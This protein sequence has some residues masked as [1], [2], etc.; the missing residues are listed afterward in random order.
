[1][2]KTLLTLCLAVITVTASAQKM[3]LGDFTKVDINGPYEVKIS[4]ANTC[5]V[6]IEASPDMAKLVEI[7]VEENELNLNCK[8]KIYEMK[9]RSYL[10]VWVDLPVL[11]RIEALG[12]SSIELQGRFNTKGKEFEVDLDDIASIKGLEIDADKCYLDLSDAAN[13]QMAG[14]VSELEIKLRSNSSAELEVFADTFKCKADGNSSF[15]SINAKTAVI[16][17]KDSS[18]GRICATE[19]LTVN[20]DNNSQLKYSG[21]NTLRIQTDIRGSSKLDKKLDFR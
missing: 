17:M 5:G 20:M 15:E 6:W 14:T 13:I 8:E 2:K 10:R 3:E 16:D 11:E 9:K 12:I 18:K 19:S 4:K 21:P 1:M 7:N